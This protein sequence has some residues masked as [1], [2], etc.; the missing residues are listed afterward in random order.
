LGE[1]FFLRP[2]DRDRYFLGL[3][4]VLQ[5]RFRQDGL[6]NIFIRWNGDVEQLL[7]D[8]VKDLVLVVKANDG[9]LRHSIVA[10]FCQIGN[11]DIK[12][13]VVRPVERPDQTLLARAR[14]AMSATAVVLIAAGQVRFTYSLAS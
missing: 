3:L 4:E 10:Q 2:S 8:W 7:P 1:L 11:Q 12:V 5:I 6:V 14:Q 13:I 9:S